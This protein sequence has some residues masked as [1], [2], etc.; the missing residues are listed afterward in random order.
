MR[1]WPRVAAYGLGLVGSA[2]A[3]GA[4]VGAVGSIIHALAFSSASHDQLWLASVAVIA[5]VCSLHELNIIQ[6]ATPQRRWQVPAAWSN[7]GK[8]LQL[9][10]YGL[11]LGADIFTLM[12]YATFYVLLLLEATLGMQGGAA[13]GAVY[14]L[15]RAL[16][17]LWG[18][19]LSR[20][21]RDTVRVAT[22]IFRAIGLFHGAN[23]V[24]LAL[25]GEVL[26]GTSLLGR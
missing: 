7:H 18:I 20:H 16:T 5:F 21:Q 8:S 3:I 17:A 1:L 6:I 19:G 23:G 10:L 14:G 25:V 11:F 24:A 12:P 4:M 2:S 26:L 22:R 15:V 13:L 9:L